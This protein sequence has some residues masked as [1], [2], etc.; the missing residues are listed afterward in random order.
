VKLTFLATLLIGLFSASSVDAGTAALRADRPIDVELDQLGS[1]PGAMDLRQQPS[2]ETDWVLVY[3]GRRMVAKA[4]VGFDGNFRIERLGGGL[5]WV[6]SPGIGQAVRVWATGTAP[7][8]SQRRLLLAST[9]SQPTAADTRTVVRGQA[10]YAIGPGSGSGY[11]VQP[12][13][14]YPFQPYQV[15]GGRIMFPGTYTSPGSA[16][17]SP[18][19]TAA[20]V[21]GIAGVI[22]VAADD[23][24]DDSTSRD[25]VGSSQSASP[26][27]DPDP[28][29][30]ASP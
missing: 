21:T 10:P 8:R 18:L 2:R 19:V 15:P 27:F 9:P 24:D 3:R 23:D 28:P 17:F 25:L 16:F 14:A 29:P 5:Y 20:V 1:L 6:T 4:R 26:E 13:P 22:I 7:P 11:V 30:P 12:A